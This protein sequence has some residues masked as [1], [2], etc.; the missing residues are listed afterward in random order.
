ML[1]SVK[2]LDVY[3]IDAAPYWRPAHDCMPRIDGHKARRIAAWKVVAADGDA[4]QNNTYRTAIQNIQ[5]RGVGLDHLDALQ[6]R[7]ILNRGL[8]LLKSCPSPRAAMV[9]P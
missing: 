6:W 2:V 5:R 8:N 3:S 7:N 4:R 9:I 1:V